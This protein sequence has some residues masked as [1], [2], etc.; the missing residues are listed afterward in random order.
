MITPSMYR[1]HLYPVLIFETRYGGVYEK[2]SW[3]SI[4]NCE[5]VPEHAVG[6]DDE[7]SSWWVSE[8][9]KMV[10]VGYTPDS[11]YVDMLNRYKMHGL[12]DE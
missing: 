7:C 11:A 3:A 5:S 1:V 9:S 6:D 12:L 10:G 4:A 8:E 2:G